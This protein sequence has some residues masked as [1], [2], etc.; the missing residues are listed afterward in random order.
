MSTPPFSSCGSSK[1]NAKIGCRMAEGPPKSSPASDEGQATMADVAAS[2]VTSLFL[3]KNRDIDLAG[4]GPSSVRM[5]AFINE[6]C[7]D[8][9]LKAE[10]LAAY[11]DEGPIDFDT[12]GLKEVAEVWH[13]PNAMWPEPIWPPKNEI[14]EDEEIEDMVRDK[15]AV[16]RAQVKSGVHNLAADIF[17]NNRDIDFSDLAAVVMTGLS[18]GLKEVA[19]RCAPAE[20]EGQTIKLTD[21]QSAKLKAA[22]EGPS[23]TCQP[24]CDCDDVVDFSQPSEIDGPPLTPFCRQYAET[25]SLLA[26]AG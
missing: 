9:D 20:D 21:E 3:L 13:S 19:D 2:A 6:F 7:K 22:Y 18:E 5:R 12:W 10:L 24:D 26:P 17:R 4:Q 1:C 8:E 14:T 11:P 15:Y 23:P 25:E 16:L